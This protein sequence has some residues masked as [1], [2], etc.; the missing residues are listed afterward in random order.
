MYFIYHCVLL[1]LLSKARAY[2]NAPELVIIHE[3]SPS[4]SVEEKRAIYKSCDLQTVSVNGLFV[5]SIT[6][7]Y[8]ITKDSGR[9]KELKFRTPIPPQAIIQKYEVKIGKGVKFE[10]KAYP[11]FLAEEIYDNTTETETCG[12]VQL[13]QDV[14]D[15]SL[16]ISNEL[17]EES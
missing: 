12:R 9:I 10:S 14:F 17:Q 16:K 2:L 7:D 11:K 13:I 1:L 15:F 8:E 6:L 5:D 3:S 4:N